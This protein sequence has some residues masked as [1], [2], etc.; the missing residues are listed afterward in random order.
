MSA[1]DFLL[2]GAVLCLVFIA[3]A[4]IY[5]DLATFRRSK[6]LSASQGFGHV[7][8]SRQPHKGIEAKS[9]KERHQ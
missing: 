4:A 6:H 7:S 8:P 3:G 1:Q 2:L 9:K 5:F